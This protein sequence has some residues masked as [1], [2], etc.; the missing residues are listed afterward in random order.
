MILLQEDGGGPVMMKDANNEYFQVGIISF[1]NGC[2]DEKFPD[3]S[4][5]IHKFWTWIHQIIAQDK[6]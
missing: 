6:C 3:A 4:V 2:G 1:G 5:N